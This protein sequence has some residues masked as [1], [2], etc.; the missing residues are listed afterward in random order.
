MNF[1]ERKYSPVIYKALQSQIK[2]F[3]ADMKANG[4]EQAKRNIDNT[5]INVPVYEAI[6]KIYRQVGIYFANDT[7]RNIL[8]QV[9]QKG[10]GFNQEWIDE[11]A[12]YFRYYLL[13]QATLPITETTKDFIRQVL[14]LGETNGWGIDE[15]VRNISTSEIT[16]HRT[17]MI[18]RTETGKAAFKGRELAKEKSPYQLTSEWIAA[19]DHR[20]RHSHKL[21]DGVVIPHSGKFSVP[22]YKRIGKVDLQIGVDL[23]DGPGDPTAHKQ[24]VINCRCTTAER[25]VFDS[26]DNPVM[27]QQNVFV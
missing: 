17:R 25:I 2:A 27:K 4:I 21:V 13:N 6:S 20:T 19:N 24:N 5:I 15:I 18:V 16:K 7:Y 23:M 12:N 22:V 3:V 9:P 11:L 1:F 14:I 8:E 10:F 26:E